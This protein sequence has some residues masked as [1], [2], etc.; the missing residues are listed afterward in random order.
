M[1]SLI[2]A[3][4]FYVLYR[5]LAA[6]DPRRQSM[7][8]A[9]LI[10]V[11]F[12]L[13][14]VMEFCA[15]FI[16][17]FVGYAGLAVLCLAPLTVVFVAGILMANGLKMFRREGRSLG[18]SLS[19]LLGIGLIVL[20]VAAILLL[21]DGGTAGPAISVFLFLISAQIGVSFLVFWTYSKLYARR[22]V[23]D[24]WDAVVV[25][26]SGLINGGVPP[27]LAARLDLGRSAFQDHRDART[28]MIPSG[29]QG[30]NEPRPEGEAMAE[31]LVDHGVAPEDVVAET[32]S[33]TTEQN[34]VY[35]RRVAT[36]AVAA[37]VH[38]EATAPALP[39]DASSGRAPHSGSQR[40]GAGR[41]PAVAQRPLLVV[42]NGYHAP[43]AALLSRR[44]KVDAQVIGARTARYFVPSAYLREFV[45]VLRMNRWLHLVVAGLSL[46][47]TLL[48]LALALNW[49]RI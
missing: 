12:A 37:R 10:C 26:G 39:D 34:L 7:A 16:D 25:L 46:A 29:G 41:G 30:P 11:W 23:L 21:V 40:D 15:Y 47:V 19:G 24:A 20:P 22:P 9:F 17:D 27:L 13:A 49:F 36:E 5:R 14:A 3:S 1:L 48:L 42:T 44:V 2:L 4:A 45:A 28:V 32:R 43:R 33:R 6:R 8:V 35:S 18:N 31:Y 38:A